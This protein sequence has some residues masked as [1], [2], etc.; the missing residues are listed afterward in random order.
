MRGLI[1]FLA[2]G[3][4]TGYAPFAPGTCGSLVAIPLIFLSASLLAFS[5]VVH[6][7]AV[8]A[9]IA[10][11]CWVAGQAE[12]Y[13]H[14]HDSG[15]PNPFH[16]VP[17]LHQYTIRPCT[18]SAVRGSDGFVKNFSVGGS[19]NHTLDG[20]V[21]ADFDTVQYDT[22]GPIIV[23]VT[24]TG[25]GTVG[26]G[27][28]GTE[29]TDTLS[30]MDLV[31][32]SNLNDVFT[33]SSGGDSF[34][35]M[36]LAGDDTF[37]GDAGFM[38][39]IA[40]F[41]DPTGITVTAEVGANDYTVTDGFGDTDTLDNI[42]T[43]FGT[44]HDDT[45]TGGTGADNFVGSLGN[46]TISGGDG[47]DFLIGDFDGFPIGLHGDD[48][49]DGGA[50]NDILVGNGGADDLTG[51]TGADTFIFGEGDGGA[52]VAL[53][54]LITD[55]E[56]GTDLIGLRGSLTFGQLTIAAEGITDTR[57]T[58]TGTGEILTVI[59]NVT[60]DLILADDFIAV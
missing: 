38:E 30:N 46:D 3:A 26:H 49:L 43:I 41:S 23:T 16:Q 60:P 52:T 53:A 47:S 55:F 50:G 57:I 20:G 39:F 13:L 45:F 58:V 7:G 8:L 4:Y 59:Q 44:D 35:W 27:A 11:A 25:A 6:I 37:N 1:L 42:D 51:G 33:N 21:D 29:F 17:L 15:K 24:G 5:S 18:K 54:D 12:S 48:V 9:I 19:G 56:D 34:Q 10:A 32:G 28:G 22:S 2:T 36:G 40:Y 14:E 31:S